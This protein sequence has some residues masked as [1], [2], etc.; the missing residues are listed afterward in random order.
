M[1]QTLHQSFACSLLRQNFLIYA[2]KLFHNITHVV[3][4][5]LTIF[6]NCI[7]NSNIR[8]L[9]IMMVN[10]CLQ[11]PSSKDVW[12]IL[13]QTYVCFWYKASLLNACTNTL[14]INAAILIRLKQN[15]I[16]IHC[17]LNLVIEKSQLQASVTI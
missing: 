17:S 14:Y 10:S 5:L 11:H 2:I 4:G 8:S 1:A 12:P 6:Y 7:L 16:Q 9:N 13:K 15:L 3:H